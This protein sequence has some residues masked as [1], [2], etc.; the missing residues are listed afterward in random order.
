[1]KTRFKL[2]LM[3][4]MLVITASCSLDPEDDGR[5]TLDDVFSRYNYTSEYLNQCRAHMPQIGF[6]YNGSTSFSSFTDDA[7]D[8]Q[9]KQ[10]S[11]AVAKW[12]ENQATS[13]S[14][15]LNSSWNYWTNMFMGIKKCNIFLDNIDHIGF[16]MEEDEKNGWKGEVLVL[17][18]FYYMQLIK[19]F[20]GVSLMDKV[21]AIYHAYSK[22]V[23]YTF[24]ECVDFFIADCDAAFALP[25]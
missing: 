10:S 22:D 14:F 1:M 25:E 8:S 19:R 24:E 4:V 23:R 17:R 12:Y 3:A 15:P 5:M 9:D 2:I 20:G 18:A 21:Y 11:K 13:S 6:S 7:Q 16:D